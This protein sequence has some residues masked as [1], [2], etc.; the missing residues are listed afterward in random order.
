MAL[1]LENLRKAVA[2]VKGEMY[3]SNEPQL[4]G[5]AKELWEERKTLSV[6]LDGLKA[7]SE[8]RDEIPGTSEYVRVQEIG[9]SLQ[10]LE[11]RL[12]ELGVAI[13]KGVES[14]RK[15]I[16]NHMGENVKS[17]EVSQDDTEEIE[18]GLKSSQEFQEYKER[19]SDAFLDLQK[20]GNDFLEANER[21]VDYVRSR[22]PHRSTSGE[23]LMNTDQFQTIKAAEQVAFEDFGELVKI[24]KD[25]EQT[26]DVDVIFH[27][28][29]TKKPLES[30][31]R[32][33]Q[34]TT[35]DAEELWGII[36]REQGKLSNEY[37]NDAQSYDEEEFLR[38]AGG[39]MRSVCE[40]SEIM[41]QRVNLYVEGLT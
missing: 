31:Q 10:K 8:G 13:P 19:L 3:E 12:A 7:N 1:N 17:A 26:D 22:A 39:L 16:G 25:I 6:E 38:G 32:V 33:F 24:R 41:K 40:T 11:A 4:E 15:V 18:S 30:M 2:E 37:K 20:V 21:F 34:R 28:A 35:H 36:L 9:L 5:A 27:K 23:E 29:R 14:L